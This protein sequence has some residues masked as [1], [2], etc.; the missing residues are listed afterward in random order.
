[1]N[2]TKAIK[3]LRDKTDEIMEISKLPD[4]QLVKKLSGHSLEELCALAN[5]N[6]RLFRAISLFVFP[7]REVDTSIVISKCEPL[8]VFNVLKYARNIKI[9]GELTV[10][11][12]LL[13]A[14]KFIQTLT[15]EESSMAFPNPFKL[16][17]FEHL[18]VINFNQC[19]VKFEH[20]RETLKTIG[21]KLEEFHWNRS[22]LCLLKT[23]FAILCL[24]DTLGQNAGNLK[25]LTINYHYEDPHEPEL[26]KSK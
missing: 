1:M 11:E 22:K 2:V 8:Y 14:A 18:R 20:L 12:N 13:L 10:N 19:I 3:L 17:H 26:D 15:I 24:T 16:Y 4:D 25:A 5:L 23:F 6:E 9:K 7:Q 21:P